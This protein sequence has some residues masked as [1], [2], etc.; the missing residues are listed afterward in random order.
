MTTL[1][2]ACGHDLDLNPELLSV[3]VCSDGGSGTV[4]PLGESANGTEFRVTAVIPAGNDAGKL[5][6]RPPASSSLDIF[7]G[8]DE[9]MTALENRKMS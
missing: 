7:T 6:F 9:V 5:Q 2:F 1:T 3:H 8:L 4:T